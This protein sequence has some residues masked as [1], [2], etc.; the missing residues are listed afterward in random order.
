VASPK[1][2]V[3]ETARTAHEADLSAWAMEQAARRR[4]AAWSRLDIDNLADEIEDVARS[5]RHALTSAPHIILLHLLEWD[6]QPERRTRS[7]AESIRTQRLAV[8]D[9]LDDSPSLNRQIGE[10]L[11][12]AYRRARVEAAGE[13]GLDEAVFPAACPYGF[14]ELMTREIPWPPASEGP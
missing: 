12:R 4:A 6:H 3:V 10:R 13:T 8:Q 11:P 14:E 1:R 9:R 5:E 2:S 7:W